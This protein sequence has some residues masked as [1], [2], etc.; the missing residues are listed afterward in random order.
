MGTDQEGNSTSM[1]ALVPRR[2]PNEK[3]EKRGN[4]RGAPRR[5][6]P[7]TEKKEGEGF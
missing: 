1:K 3:K 7:M 6:Y 5:P 2:G 4:I